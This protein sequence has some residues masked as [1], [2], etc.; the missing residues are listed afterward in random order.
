MIPYTIRRRTR[1]ATNYREQ[2]EFTSG[3]GDISIEFRTIFQLAG[4]CE[5][6]I[7]ARMEVGWTDGNIGELRRRS[8]SSATIFRQK[9]SGF[10]RFKHGCYH[11]NF[12]RWR[13]LILDDPN[14]ATT[15][16]A[17]FMDVAKL[18]TKMILR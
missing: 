8:H 11:R 18:L 9:C 16:L 15:I 3:A 13:I 4:K 7:S 6:F 17:L 1:I 2:F 10:W 12:G 5:P 14:T